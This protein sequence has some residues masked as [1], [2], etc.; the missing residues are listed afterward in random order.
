LI[1]LAEQ[2][3]LLRM[4]RG[5]VIRYEES[6]FLDIIRDAALRAGIEDP[7]FAE[8]I[9]RGIVLYL[10]ERF[11]HSSIGLDELFSKIAD[12]LQA[13]G[14]PHIAHNLERSAPPASMCLA[15]LAEAAGEGFEL[16]FFHLLGSALRDARER[17]SVQLQCAGLHD[18][19]NRLCRTK[20]WGRRCDALRDEILTFVASEFAQGSADGSSSR[21]LAICA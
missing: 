1:A 14:F 12:T 8:H 3:P 10:R 13:V 7:W 16:S 19:V 15:S 21:R 18:A 11:V 6:W 4:P 17:G 9:A 20:R 5:E 2:L